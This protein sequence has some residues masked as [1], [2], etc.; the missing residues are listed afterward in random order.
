MPMHIARFPATKDRF[1]GSSSISASNIRSPAAVSPMRKRRV[2]TW[3]TLQDIGE[4]VSSERKS[5][6]S[7][8]SDEDIQEAEKAIGDIPNDLLNLYNQRNGGIPSRTLFTGESENEYRLDYLFRSP[9]SDW[10]QLIKTL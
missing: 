4:T 3:N 1:I 7:S 10:N 5:H 2:G 9:R 8:L 6:A